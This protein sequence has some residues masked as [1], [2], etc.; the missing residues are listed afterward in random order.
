M[1]AAIYDV[2]TP[3]IPK[4]EC[5]A[6]SVRMLRE[7]YEPDVRALRAVVG[8]PLHDAWERRFALVPAGSTKA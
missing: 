3:R 8:R 6:E 7:V 4:P 2:L 5:D 1:R